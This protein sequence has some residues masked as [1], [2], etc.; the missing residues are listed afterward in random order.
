MV[1][2]GFWDTA[3]VRTSVR[4]LVGVELGILLAQPVQEGLGLP[5][6]SLRGCEK[7][8]APHVEP[9]PPRRA[10]ELAR[11]RTRTRSRGGVALARVHLYA[12]AFQCLPARPVCVHMSFQRSDAISGCY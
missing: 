6:Q 4:Y 5:A 9:H 3:L 8:S 1:A 11:G 7:V 12:R 2:C 10:A